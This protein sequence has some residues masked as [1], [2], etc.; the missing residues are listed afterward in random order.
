MK[1]DTKAKD[2][3][4]EAC[5]KLSLEYEG[6]KLCEAKSSG[7]VVVFNPNDLSISTEISVNGRLYVVPEEPPKTIVSYMNT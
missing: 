2:I 5:N 3:L 7:E 6:H 4:K 1:L